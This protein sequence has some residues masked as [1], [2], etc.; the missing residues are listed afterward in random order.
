MNT[1]NA[2]LRLSDSLSDKTRDR[3]PDIVF[4]LDEVEI[5][6]IRTDTEHPELPFADGE[7]G[8]IVVYDDALS[9]VIDEETWLQEFQRVLTAGGGLR[10]T[11]PATGALAWLDAMNTYRYISDIIGRGDEPNASLPTGWNRHYSQQ[12]IEHLLDGAGFSAPTFQ[13]QNYAS[14]EFGMLLG[15]VQEN[16]LKKNRHAERELFARYGK[17]DPND[18]SWPLP[19]T[20]SV[21]TT[22]IASNEEGD[23]IPESP[24][25]TPSEISTE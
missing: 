16:L 15:L 7:I 11:L 13:K 20:W 24:S 25:D 5:A 2:H 8:S 23:P 18:D 10:F 22:S 6:A 14:Q 9:R 21:R 17:R 12:H 19:T 3:C 1:L 4:K